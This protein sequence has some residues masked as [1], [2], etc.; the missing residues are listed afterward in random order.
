MNLHRDASLAFGAA[1]AETKDVASPVL[2]LLSHGFQITWFRETGRK[3]WLAAVKPLPGVS[4]HFGL[5]AEYFVVGNGYP[6]DFYQRTLKVDPPPELQERLNNSVRF[7]AADAVSA[8]ALCAAWAQKN[9]CTVVL[10]KN[11]VGSATTIDR[12]YS[13]LSSALWRRDYFA[14]AEPVR[15]P[16]EFYGRELVVNEL[17][18]KVLLGAPV[19][20]FGLRKIGKSSLLG[21]VEDLIEGDDS[22]VVATAF[23]IGNATRLKSGR[24]WHAAQDMTAAWQNKLQRLAAQH[25]SKVHAKAER[26]SEAIAKKV[27]DA[28]QLA[29]A[30]ERDV[31]A[32][33]KAARVLA[34]ELSR[35]SVKLVLFL[36]ECDHMWPHLPDSGYWKTDF[37]P[38]WNTLQ[39]IKRGLPNPDELVYVLSGVNPSG[40]EQG[41][42]ADHANPLFEVQR[43]YL[44]PLTKP[45]ADALLIGLGSRMGLV[46]EADALHAAYELVGGHPLLL[47]RLGTAIHEVALNRSERKRLSTQDVKR[48][49]SKKKRDLYNQVTWILEHLA[50]VAPDE[51][52]LLRDVAG[53]GSQA[54]AELWHDNDFRETYAH[55]LERYGLLSFDSELPTVS[56]SLIK[57]ALR[58]PAASEFSEQKK[59]LKLAIEGME[60]AIRIRLKADVERECTS[61]EAVLRIVNAIPSDA[62]N[63]SLDRQEL[64][65]LGEAAGVSAV[66][67]S[68]NWGDYQILLDKWHDDI[69]WAGKSLS[70]DERAASIREVFG[71][72]HVVRHNNDHALKQ[73]I[74]KRGFT[75]LFNGFTQI[76]EMMS[77]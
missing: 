35:D 7:I 37:F 28:Q 72:A 60:I 18:S 14:E 42:L 71:D 52:R 59:Q 54:Y 58:Q 49:F 27:A 51:E 4:D 36:D 10:L 15:D 5:Q 44:G 46:F 66:L 21:R 20:V 61:Q 41:T 9:K 12:L 48:A 17:Q 6:T 70:K 2:D 3:L 30:F 40:V 38:L 24:W 45:E 19:A 50:K 73:L 62:K 53:G 11:V 63:R 75:P 8:D 16:S 25:G 76:R 23:L 65:D 29:V 13:L 56:L 31:T 26:L 1:H 34:S 32:L 39:A 74:D 69:T 67:E 77:A 47:R 33:L 22:S 57:D 68:L 43:I 64:Q 55:H